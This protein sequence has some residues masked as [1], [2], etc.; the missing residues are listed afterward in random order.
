LAKNEYV[1]C[2]RCK[3][4]ILKDHIDN[5]EY[6]CIKNGGHAIGQKRTKV[7]APTS[8]PLQQQV[9]RIP[10]PKPRYREPRQKPHYIYEEEPPEQIAPWRNA[11]AVGLLGFLMGWIMAW[12]ILIALKAYV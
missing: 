12:M 1:I 6:K 9:H 7:Q 2:P 5:Y 4:P 11:L 8:T 10:E 3:Q